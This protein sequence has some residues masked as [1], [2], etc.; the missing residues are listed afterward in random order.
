MSNSQ[1]LYDF[2]CKIWEKACDILASIADLLTLAQDTNE[3]VNEI[4]EREPICMIVESGGKELEN[5]KCRNDIVVDGPSLSGGWVNSTTDCLQCGDGDVCAKFKVWQKDTPRAYMMIGLSDT[6]GA[7]QSFQDIDFAIYTIIRNDIAT[8]QWY[9]YIYENGTNRGWKRLFRDGI[10][11]CVEYEI[12]RVGAVIEY[13]VDGEIAYTAA[14]TTGGA[15]LCL[16]SSINNNLTTGTPC[17]TGQS[18]CEIVGGESAGRAP[19]LR[20]QGLNADSDF[21]LPEH[22]PLLAEQLINGAE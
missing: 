8:P 20:A 19:S 10:P 14:D 15:T 22:D 17:I 5:C 12:R 11:D 4:K 16:D 7:N 18:V 1:T 9:V 3:C 2:L 13:L 21:F 6:C